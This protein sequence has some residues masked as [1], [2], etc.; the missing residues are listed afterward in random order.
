MSNWTELDAAVSILETTPLV[1]MQCTSIYPCPPEKVGLNVIREMEDR[2]NIPIGYSDHTIGHA[3][4][5]AAA[6]IG[7][8]VIEKHL[9]FSRVM[10]GSDAVNAMEPDDFKIYIRFKFTLNET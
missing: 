8:T 10:Y 3:A 6:A 1:V 7:A 4:A 2:Y 5:F 9:T